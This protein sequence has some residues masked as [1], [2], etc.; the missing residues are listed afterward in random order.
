M[1]EF[2]NRVLNDSTTIT[3]VSPESGNIIRE[4]LL[5]GPNGFLLVRSYWDVNELKTAILFG[6]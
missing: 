3:G 4:A 2:F 1:T 5:A 6:G